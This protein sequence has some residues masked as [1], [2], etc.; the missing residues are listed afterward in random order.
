M[1]V[2]TNHRSLPLDAS[3]TQKKPSEVSSEPPAK[4]ERTDEVRVS[5]EA[6]ELAGARGVEVPDQARIDRLKEAIANGS[7]RIDVDRIA[8]RMIDEE[9]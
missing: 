5:R 7:F 8:S 6:Q 4:A 2:D 9:T 3:R 1:K